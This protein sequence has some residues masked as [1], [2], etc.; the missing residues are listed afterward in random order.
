MPHV[1]L[2]EDNEH[3]RRIYSAKL[4]AEGFKLTTAENGEQALLW[5]EVCRPDVI[6]LDIMLPKMDGF[7][8]LKRLRADPHLSRI[9]VF[10]L[11]NKASAED[12]Q[13]A[14]SLGAREF[15]TKGSLTLQNVVT[16]IGNECGFKKLLAITANV[17]SAKSISAALLHPKLLCAVCTV[18]AEAM[19][20][21]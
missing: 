16:Q 19:T 7:E 1:L 17:E 12:V 4:Q 15:F 21:V 3:I 8:V 13:Y 20:A 10:M 9:P 5:A 6:L 14:F 11:S 2:I 18:L